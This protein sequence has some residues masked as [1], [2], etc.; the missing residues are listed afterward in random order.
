MAKPLLN[1]ILSE[2]AAKEAKRERM[3]TAT[4]KRRLEIVT[5]VPISI[6]KVVMS[7]PRASR[8]LQMLHGFFDQWRHSDKTRRLL[9]RKVEK[10]YDEK[11]WQLKM[12]LRENEV[13]KAKLEAAAPLKRRKVETSPNSRFVNIRAIRRAQ[14]EAGVIEAESAD[15]EGSEGSETPNSCIVVGSGEDDSDVEVE[16]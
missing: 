7:T 1:A 11:D 16:G 5:P 12:A 15:E 4:R 3:K 9:F 2:N 6:K 10:G 8:E 13:L 14:I